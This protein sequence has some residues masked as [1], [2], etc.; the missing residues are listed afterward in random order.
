LSEFSVDPSEQADEADK[1]SGGLTGVRLTQGMAA[2]RAKLRRQ[3]GILRLAIAH[4]PKLGGAA[5][6][7]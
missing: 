2:Q 3:V 1:L 4:G 7:K 6:E 5:C